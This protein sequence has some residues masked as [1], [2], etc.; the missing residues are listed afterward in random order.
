VDAN[1]SLRL[2]GSN[3]GC[4]GNSCQNTC[5][6]I[7]PSKTYEVTGLLTMD[8]GQTVGL[9]MSTGKDIE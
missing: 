6:F 2:A 8:A 7:D 1:R 9:D 3:S 5:P 4:T